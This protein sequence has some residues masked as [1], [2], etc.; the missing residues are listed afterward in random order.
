MFQT[1]NQNYENEANFLRKESY[2]YH[3]KFDIE[4]YNENL[5]EL[6]IEIIGKD[7]FVPKTKEQICTEL[8]NDA[9][10]Y[11]IQCH[12]NDTE[13]KRNSLYK[14][15]C[16]QIQF[17][18]LSDEDKDEDEEFET[19]NNHFLNTYELWHKRLDDNPCKPEGLLDQTH[20]EELF[21]IDKSN[22]N[23]KESDFIPLPIDKPWGLKDAVKKVYKNPSKEIF[24]FDKEENI[25]RSTEGR[26]FQNGKIVSNGIYKSTIE[27]KSYPQKSIN[28]KSRYVHRDLFK[29]FIGKN[30][31]PE[32]VNH[33]NGDI[34]NISIINFE[35][36]DRSHNGFHAIYELKKGNAI[37]IKKFDLKDTSNV[38]V[39][40]SITSAAKDAQYSTNWVS[41]NIATKEFC[42][43]K[44]KKYRYVYENSTYVPSKRIVLD[45]LPEGCKPLTL[46]RQDGKEFSFYGEKNIYHVSR[47]GEL[48]KEF[49]QKKYYKM[50]TRIIGSYINV[51]VTD[52]K[53]N[54]KSYG[55]QRVVLIVHLDGK[56]GRTDEHQDY[57]KL[58]VD[59]KNRIRSDNRKENLQF[60]TPSENSLLAFGLKP[61]IM[62]SIENCSLEQYR[63]NKTQGNIIYD[64]LFADVR[65]VDE[66]LNCHIATIQSAAANNFIMFNYIFDYVSDEFY[67]KFKNNQN[68]IHVKKEHASKLFGHIQSLTTGKTFTFDSFPDLES[69]Q[70]LG[71]KEDQ[72]HIYY[73]DNIKNSIPGV[74]L[75]NG[76]KQR[77]FIFAKFKQNND[78]K[79]R[80]EFEF[81]N[82]L[83]SIIDEKGKQG[84]PKKCWITRYINGISQITEHVTFV[85]AN[86]F[87][88]LDHHQITHY[89]NG[90]KDMFNSFTHN[91]Q[92]Y[93]E[94]ACCIRKE[95]N[96]YKYLNS[97]IEEFE[98]FKCIVN[99][100]S[101]IIFKKYQTKEKNAIFELCYPCKYQK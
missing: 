36:S 96:G 31:N 11:M 52:D 15:I 86:N 62:L 63:Y 45:K 23:P 2:Y 81:E 91:G 34:H 14:E 53:G 33:V 43:S 4:Y 41:W 83:I 93:K 12:M 88:N 51:N 8:W 32:M 90:H 17:F 73:R 49:E 99:D 48:F 55:M 69:I 42:D 22:K 6:Y 24:S 16:D 7:D 40:D 64:G 59:H 87:L 35:A 58:F 54:H 37:K 82:I 76:T 71:I 18:N 13:E 30:C 60:V 10:D 26:H 78:Y 84:K 25:R 3:E 68:D 29:A 20:Y 57:T 98:P 56:T 66:F 101:E 38:Q 46:I 80:S 5:R 1:S 100:S 28:G 94:Y 65:V 67:E 85:E 50:K 75:P 9:R 89:I 44:D 21:M 79:I 61:L 27:N 97:K 95:D 74:I 92:Q 70:K 72:M 39:F 19:E 77:E 47:E